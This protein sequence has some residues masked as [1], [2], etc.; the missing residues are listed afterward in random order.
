VGY[1]YPWLDLDKWALEIEEQ[2]LSGNFDGRRQDLQAKL[3]RIAMVRDRIYKRYQ[4]FHCDYIPSY[5]AERLIPPSSDS[6]VS[7]KSI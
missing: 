6:G 7:K 5:C 2:L 1:P 3:S 4:C